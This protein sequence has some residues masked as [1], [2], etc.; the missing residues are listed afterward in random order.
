MNSKK[1]TTENMSLADQLQQKTL[2][3]VNASSAL[4]A[5]QDQFKLVRTQLDQAQAAYDNAMLD[6]QAESTQLF[7]AVVVKDIAR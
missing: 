1:K 5:K 4:K 7:Q 6:Y 2:A 3:L